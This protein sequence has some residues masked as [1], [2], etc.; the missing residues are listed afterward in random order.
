M[1]CQRCGM[2]AQ[3]DLCQSCQHVERQRERYG[4]PAENRERRDDL[5]GDDE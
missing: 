1:T 3:N 4:T 5:E 2:P